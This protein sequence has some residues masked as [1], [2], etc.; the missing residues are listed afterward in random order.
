M[1]VSREQAKEV[2]GRA[3]EHHQK[4]EQQP[5]GNGQ[6]QPL[7]INALCL[8][9]AEWEAREI[10]PD[11]MLLG[12]FSVSTRT[13]LAADTGLGKTM[14]GVALA[15]AMATGSDFLHWRAVRHAR[16]LFIDGEMPQGLLKARLRVA[17]SWFGLAE[18]LGRDRLC[19]LSAADLEDMPPIDTS[20]G[21]RWVFDLIDKLGRFDHVTFDNRASLAAGDLAGDDASTTAIKLL[22]RQITRLGTGQLW[23]HHTGL[24]GSRGYG[25]KAREWEMDTVGIGERLNDRQDAD[26]AMKLRFT[27]ARRRTPDTRADYEPVELELSGNR[28]SCSHTPGDKIPSRKLGSNQRAILDAAIKLL[29]GSDLKPPPGHPAGNNT[30][31][32]TKTL[33]DET[34]SVLACEPKRFTGRFHEALN[35]LTSAHHLSLYGEYVWRA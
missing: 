11:D 27:K 8:S 13:E 15:H 5:K 25:R 34:R 22:Q 28:W 16:V 1:S 23:L 20:E 12:P 3:R 35:G 29:A 32:R 2:A 19:V 9:P 33:E 6:A 7:D 4:Q 18:P 24:D 17:R 31:I 30:V 14:F 10:P 21:A 26:V